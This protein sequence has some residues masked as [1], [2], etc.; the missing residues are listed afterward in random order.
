[1]SG[2]PLRAI[3]CAGVAGVAGALSAQTNAFVGLGVLSL[4]TTKFEPNPVNIDPSWVEILAGVYRM[5]G[6]LLLVLDV[7]RA[8][9]RISASLAA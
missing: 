9:A 5:P 6:E 1:M 8:L 7:E 4:D 2:P 3:A